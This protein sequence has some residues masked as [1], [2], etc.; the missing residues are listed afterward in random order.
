MKPGNHLASTPR[1]P[2][3]S[4]LAFSLFEVMIAIG[5]F[6]MVSFAILALVSSGLRTARALRVTRPSAGLLAAELSLT[7]QLAEGTDSGNFGNLYPDYTWN[8]ETYEAYTNGL[9]QVDFVVHKRGQSGAPDSR[10]S[11]FMFSP[12]SRSGRLGLQP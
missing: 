11:I 5:I 3:R 7:N 4:V 9:W 10:M 2:A 1:P 6:F 12:G 8:S